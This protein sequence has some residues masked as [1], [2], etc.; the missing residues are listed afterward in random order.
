MN[1]VVRII[2]NNDFRK[3]ITAALPICHNVS[4]IDCRHICVFAGDARIGACMYEA[5]WSIRYRI[6]ENPTLE[7]KKSQVLEMILKINENVNTQ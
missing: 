7:I 2:P 3:W 1:R 6:Q 4:Y 5:M